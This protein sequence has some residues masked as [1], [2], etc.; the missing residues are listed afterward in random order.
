[1]REKERIKRILNLL[2]KYWNK[3]PDQRFGQMLINLRIIPDNYG[4][5]KNEDDGFE[6]YL[7]E[8]IKNE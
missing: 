5:W 2:E 7:K 3:H 1:M 8:V 4:V 6:K